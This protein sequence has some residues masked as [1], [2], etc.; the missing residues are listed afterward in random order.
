MRDRIPATWKENGVGTVMSN[1]DHTIDYDVL[2]KLDKPRT[3]AAYAG[4]NF[5]GYVWKHSKGYSCEVWQ[6]KEYVETIHG[7][8]CT[9]IMSAVS[10]G[11]GN[12]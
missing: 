4:W 11:S 6:Y 5:Y 12:G 8:D 2:K 7:Q 3:W 10:A 9:D 1:M